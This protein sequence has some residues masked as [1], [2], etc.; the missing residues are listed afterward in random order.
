MIVNK[1]KDKDEYLQEHIFIFNN[2]KTQIFDNNVNLGLSIKLHS[3]AANLMPLS[4]KIYCNPMPS[5]LKIF[6]TLNTNGDI[7]LNYLT[8]EE[9]KEIINKQIICF[10]FPPLINIIND[11]R[12]RKLYIKN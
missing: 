4:D 5:M 11:N 2:I 1:Y 8:D 12:L 3:Y 10:K 7:K 6:N 9:K